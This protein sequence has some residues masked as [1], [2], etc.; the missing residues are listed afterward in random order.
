[1]ANDA[2]EYKDNIFQAKNHLNLKGYKINSLCSPFEDGDA[3]TK[4]YVD[5]ATVPFLKLDQT[6]YKTKGDIDMDGLYTVYNVKKPIDGKHIA[7]KKY[8]DEMDNL[9]SAFVFRNG[10]YDAKGSIFMRKNKL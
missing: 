3:A 10:G 5:T 9:K 7:D 6:K 4:G 1:M 2:F 8:V